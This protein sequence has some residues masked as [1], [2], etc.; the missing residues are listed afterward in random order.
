MA[1]V[2]AISLERTGVRGDRRFYLVN[3]DGILINAKRAPSLLTVRP[4]IDDDHLVLHFPDG[5]SVEG[6]VALGERVETNFYGR[7]VAG[8]VVAGPWGEAL[9]E[10]AG[11]PLRLVKTAREGDGLDR[12]Q[13]AGATLVSTASLEALRAAAGATG[14]V[15]GRRFRMTIG[16]EGV[17]A[18]AEDGWL[19][20]NVRVGRALVLLRGNVGRC[21]V[22]T[23]DPDRGVRD[24]ET[25]DVIADYRAEVPT[26][27][28]LPFGVWGEVVEPGRIEVGDAIEAMLDDR[29]FAD[30]GRGSVL[31]SPSTSP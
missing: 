24:L 8:R 23:L 19:G 9:S 30:A 25:L 13:S 1:S 21:A 22:T 31:E 4:E 12:G 3:E 10:H 26:S 17:D 29:L 6:E 20:S 15:D 16:I 27:E 11:M 18:H 7:P 14:P 5:A 2:G 28:R